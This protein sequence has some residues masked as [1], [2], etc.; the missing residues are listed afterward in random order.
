MHLSFSRVFTL[1]HF[2]FRIFVN[3][4][5]HQNRQNKHKDNSTI[6]KGHE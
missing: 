1:Y 4:F 3:L 5:L 6:T 2:R